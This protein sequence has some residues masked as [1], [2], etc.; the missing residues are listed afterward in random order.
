M[1]TESCTAVV[2]KA[3]FWRSFFNDQYHFDDVKMSAMA[4]HI[5][6]VSF[7]YSTVY[8]DADQSKHESSALLA[9]VR[10]IHR[11]PVTVQRASNAEKFPFDDVIMHS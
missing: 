3:V 7:V 11:L 8:S 6:G 10:G 2:R 4:S 1:T 5:T 9:L